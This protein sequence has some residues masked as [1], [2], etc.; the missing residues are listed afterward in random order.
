MASIAPPSTE[1]RVRFATA[2]HRGERVHLIVEALP[3]SDECDWLVWKHDSPSA[4]RS[5][6]PLSVSMAIAAAE[7][8]AR[9]ILTGDV[10]V[11]WRVAETP[12]D[13]PVIQTNDGFKIAAER[14]RARF[15]GGIWE[16]MSAPEQAGAIYE[17]LRAVDLDLVNKTREGPAP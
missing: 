14:A 7:Q 15:P 13:A 10:P 1:Q 17:A 12:R 9:D 6:K 4:T 5:R 11:D 2:S 16:R 3:G 8:A